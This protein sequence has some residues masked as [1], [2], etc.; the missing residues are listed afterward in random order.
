LSRALR[1]ECLV[2]YRDDLAV[3]FARASPPYVLPELLGVLIIC[4]KQAFE[5]RRDE[6]A[7][8]LF[9]G[10]LHHVALGNKCNGA[11]GSHEDMR[12]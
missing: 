6:N 8:E 7:K 10:E 4:L 11:I 12:R 5:H 9:C 2:Y 3:I 1:H